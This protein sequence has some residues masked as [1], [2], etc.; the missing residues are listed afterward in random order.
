MLCQVDYQN[1]ELS[2]LDTV[3]HGADTV[4]A[5]MANLIKKENRIIYLVRVQ[6]SHNPIFF[7]VIS[8]KIKSVFVKKQRENILR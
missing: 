7:C 5:L 1:A 2:V 4:L 3:E 6:L 8:L